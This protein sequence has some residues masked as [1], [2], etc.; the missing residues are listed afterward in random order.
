MI[1]SGLDQVPEI[2]IQIFA[3]GDG[4]VGLIFGLADE[5]DLVRA[6]GAVVAPEVVGVKE[7]EDAASRLVADA[8]G[9]L[10]C[11]GAGEEEIGSRRAGGSDEDPAFAGAHVGV[12]EEAEAEDV[13]V[14]GDGFV[15]VADD[16]GDVGEGLG[17]R[18]IVTAVVG[19]RSS[20]RADSSFARC[21]PPSERHGG[22]E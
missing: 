17:H 15:V 12:F 9:L 21:A 19:R 7:E 16:E 2:S 18:R 20:A 14:I 4:A 22:R 13:G 5:F 1:L 3:D 11:G 6:E 8:G 10:G